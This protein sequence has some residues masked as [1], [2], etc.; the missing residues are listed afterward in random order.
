[1]VQPEIQNYNQNQLPQKT[2]E[3]Y[4]QNLDFCSSK[5]VGSVEVQHKLLQTLLLDLKDK[6][7]AVFPSL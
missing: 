6:V 4:G 1:M 5:N 3:H 2:V 7:F